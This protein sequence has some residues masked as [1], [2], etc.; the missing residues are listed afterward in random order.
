MRMNSVINSHSQ[1]RLGTH[2]SRRTEWRWYPRKCSAAR[3]DP[4][5][6]AYVTGS[7]RVSPGVPSHGSR[8]RCSRSPG[9]TWTWLPA[10]LLLNPGGGRRA[11]TPETP[12][13]KFDQ[14]PPRRWSRLEKGAERRPCGMKRREEG[15]ESTARMVTFTHGCAAAI[16]LLLLWCPPLLFSFS[17]S[18]LAS[19]NQWLFPSQVTLSLSLNC[20]HS[21]PF[22][23]W[24]MAAQTQKGTMALN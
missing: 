22:T 6:R 2:G 8:R 9:E 15:G 13:S 21:H 18:L 23:L 11:A 24:L 14:R 1:I 5:S 10:L 7:N 16:P 12:R 3:S 20:C 17:P 19:S 4:A